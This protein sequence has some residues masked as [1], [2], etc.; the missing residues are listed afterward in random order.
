MDYMP[1]G[2]MW[3]KVSQE[4]YLS[5]ELAGFYAAELILAVEHLHKKGIMYW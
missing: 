3:H 1:R 5:E 2:T 4:K